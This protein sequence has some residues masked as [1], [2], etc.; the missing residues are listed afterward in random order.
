[1]SKLH[2]SGFIVRT[3]GRLSLLFG[4]LF[5]IL[6]AAQ[7]P[8]KKKIAKE[9]DLPVFQYHLA[10]KVEDLIQSDAA[11]RPLAQQIRANM[12][13]VLRDYEIEDNATRRSLLNALAALDVLDRKDEQARKELAEVKSLQEKPAQKQL[14]GIVT[15]AI[16]DGRAHNPDSTSQA[17]RQAVGD[18]MK[19]RLNQLDYQVVEA[20]LKHLKAGLQVLNQG[21]LLGQL[22]S[23]FDP[24][25][26]KTGV[27]SSELANQLPSVRLSLVDRLPVAPVLIQALS[28]CIASHNTDKQDIW[29]ARS[30][31]LAPGKNYT[32]VRVAVWD[33]GVD[34]S[35][36][37][38]QLLIDGDDRPAVIAYDLQSQETTGYLFPLS[39]E[40]QLVYFK[41]E[42]ELKGISD[43]Q[44]NIDSPEATKL[45][46]RL[47]A[48]KPGDVKSFTDELH[49][50]SDFAHGTHVAGIFLDGNPYAQLVVGR[51]TFD[52]K[53]IPDPCPSRELS[54][55]SAR[56]FADFVNFFKEHGVRVVNMSWGGSERDV[57]DSLEMCATGMS[58]DQRRQKARELFEIEKAALTGAISSAPGILFITS[59]GNA[60]NNAS[61]TESFPSS[62]QLSNLLTVGA[63]DQSGAE[64]VFTSY[65][66]TVYVD[67][68]GHEVES[69]VPGGDRLKMSGTSMAAPSAANLAAKILAVNS[70]LTPPQ[71]IEIIRDTADSSTDG[72]RHLMNPKKAVAEAEA[73]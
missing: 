68:N 27:I 39:P 58:S 35:V 44:A 53:T 19:Q 62:L 72:R 17:Y 5:G 4:F 73:N 22:Q 38:K 48:M 32:P 21:V 56:A 11:F 26:A 25:V 37:K 49:L 52:W 46:Q 18:S 59:A 43:L 42:E 69:F 29:A 1:M 7:A 3:S 67:A 45:R 6:L 40:Q 71:V 13:S 15:L 66:P 31:T 23:V 54:E 24:I 33:S 12:E 41:V 28:V 61:F 14:S 16:L 51:L 34:I 47:A 70:K 9:A 65:G 20:D 57:E 2:L 30:V 64:A 63:V 55:R 36:Y 50:Y 8:P 60:N 10:G